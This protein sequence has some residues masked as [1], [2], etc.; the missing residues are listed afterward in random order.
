MT[1]ENANDVPRALRTK[2]DLTPKNW[3]KCFVAMSQQLKLDHELS[4]EAR[5]AL[6]YVRKAEAARQLV[7]MLINSGAILFE[8][9]EAGLI[10][11]TIVV[12]CPV[13]PC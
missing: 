5:I 10:T 12:T 11:A 1:D 3:P 8:D 9:T 2:A 7:P 4:A 13:E 6:D